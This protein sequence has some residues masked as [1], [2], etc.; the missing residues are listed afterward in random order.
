MIIQGK[1]LRNFTTRVPLKDVI[2][3][4]TPFV[5]Y[6]E[7]TN[8][9]VLHC[10]FC[11][12]GNP[13]VLEKIGRPLG[14][15]DWDMFL[16]VVNDLSK[17]PKQLQRVNLYKDG[18]PLVN[19]NFSKMVKI[20]KQKGVTKEVWT[21]TNGLLLKHPL[22]KE[23]VNC[24]LDMIGISI[25]QVTADGYEKITGKRINFETLVNNIHDLFTLKNDT[26]SKLRIYIS[27]ADSGLTENEIQTFYE[28]FEPISDYCAVEHLHG[29]SMSGIKDFTLGVKQESFDG[30][31]LVPKIVCPW[32]FYTFTI[33]FN[34]KI[35]VCNEDFAYT[36]VVGDVN[37]ETLINIWNGDR[38]FDFRKMLL[39]G[40]RRENPSCN[41]CYYLQCLPDNID[42]ERAEILKRMEN[43]KK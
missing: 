41:N 24:G 42:N 19:K 15:M 21:K 35:T 7:P 13:D 37:T 30:V 3:L 32:P 11:P 31:P 6:I 2:P 8:R 20:L 38:F 12:T 36:T 28:I 22:N 5:V 43:G 16:K 29:W 18:E 25:K 40:R 33:N 1:D 34:G 14:T 27:I 4:D 26:V 17:F 39:E 23:L 10:S 9:C